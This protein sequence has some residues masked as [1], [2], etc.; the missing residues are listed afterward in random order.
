VTGS[1][2][3]IVSGIVE[4][5]RLDMKEPFGT[6]YVGITDKTEILEDSTMW[7]L[8]LDV[9]AANN[10]WIKNPDADMEMKGN[11]KVLRKAGIQN[12]LG[13]LDV[14][15]GNFF[16]FNYKFKVQSGQMNFNNISILDPLISFDV[17]TRVRETASSSLMNQTNLGYEDLNL[18]ITG[19]LSK[20]KIQSA[21]DSLYSDEDIL[22]ILVSDRFSVSAN[23]GKNAGLG[24]K[25]LA[26]ML[27]ILYNQTNR[28]PVFDEVDIS[29]YADSLGQTQVSVAKYLSPKLFLRY[30]RRGFSQSSGET[31]GI[32]YMLNNNLSFE[33]KQGTKNEGISFDL[34]LKYE[35]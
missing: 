23:S 35:F 19:T 18:L 31:I 1:A 5:T 14:I 7:D 27:D 2:P 10:L 11:V 33:G 21:S 20:P 24:E 29:P 4:L 6:F 17:S 8:D 15:R 12:L 22:K 25:L 34:K 30:S 16:L 28:I 3:P 9:T 13:Q 26:N 32:E